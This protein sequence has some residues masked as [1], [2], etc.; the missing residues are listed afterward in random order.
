[1]GTKRNPWVLEGDMYVMTAY[2]TDPS[3][4]CN[5]CRKGKYYGDRLLI[6]DGT[7]N[8]TIVIPFKEDDLAGSKWVEGRCFPLMGMW[9][10]LYDII[11][12]YLYLIIIIIIIIIINIVIIVVIIVVIVIVINIVN[13]YNIIITKIR[14]KLSLSLLWLL[15]GVCS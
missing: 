4:I 11:N 8:S 5:M 3:T 1:V 15:M 9:N 10:D 6:L 7:T 2:F 13:Y 14:M 12:L